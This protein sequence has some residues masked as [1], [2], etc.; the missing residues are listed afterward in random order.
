[1]MG[2]GIMHV[3]TE[4]LRSAY[5]SGPDAV[6]YGNSAVI[7]KMTDFNGNVRTLTVTTDRINRHQIKYSLKAPD[8]SI[9]SGLWDSEQPAPLP[10]A[11]DIR[12]W[13]HK[14]P[15]TVKTLLDVRSL[16]P[17]KARPMK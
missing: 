12:E 3:V 15:G 6:P 13:R 1:M 17:E 14:A 9:I 5:P 16:K 4:A 11:Y 10:D 2:F 8:E 7:T